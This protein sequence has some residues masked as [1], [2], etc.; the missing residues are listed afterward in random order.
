MAT[1]H[2]KDNGDP[3]RCFARPGNCP[4]GPG[5]EH[6]SNKED[7]RKA[8]EEKLAREMGGGFGRERENSVP[9][10]APYTFSGDIET[11]IAKRGTNGFSCRKCGTR[12]STKQA[13][14]LVNKKS[15]TC[16][17]GDE[18]S[19]RNVHSGVW[20]EDSPR[21][22]LHADTTFFHAS[23]TPI[24]EA[25]GE[26][27]RLKKAWGRQYATGT[28]SEEFKAK[29]HGAFLSDMGTTPQYAIDSMLSGDS[30]GKGFYVYELERP[31]A[32][33]SPKALGLGNGEID[34]SNPVKEADRLRDETGED[35][36]FYSFDSRINDPGSKGYAVDLANMT[37]KAKR[38]VSAEEAAKSPSLYNL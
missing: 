21:T 5:E 25:I 36:G 3:G 26:S 22:S 10:L 17:C 1:Y 20:Q 19:L 9:E 34:F 12:T 30:V 6:Y 32:K 18:V 23:V 27:Q 37:I 28:V 13:G 16:Q 4:K 8:S 35:R 15:Y 14:A 33:V 24:D 11:E 38:W 31:D 7:A 29:R 2:L